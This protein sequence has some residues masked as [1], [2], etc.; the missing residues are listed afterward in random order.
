M[1]VLDNYR[2]NKSIAVLLSSGGASFPERLQ[3]ISRLR[4]LGGRAVPKLIRAL[5]AFESPAPVVELLATLLDNNT[6]PLFFE[7]LTSPNPLV[8]AGVVQVL[9]RRGTYDPNRLVELFQDAK[10]PKSRLVEILSAQKAD[11]NPR[12]LLRLLDTMDKDSR[13]PIFRLL[14]EVATESVTPDLIRRLKSDDWLLRLNIARILHRFST[15]AVRDALTALLADPHKGVRQAALEGLA[16][17]KMPVDVAPICKLLRDPDLTVQSKAIEAIGRI[18]DAKAVEYLLDILQD[19]SEY[20]RR[21]AVEVLNQVG[22][23]DAIKDLL[24]ALRDKDWWVRVRAAD[25]LGTIGGTKVVDAVLALVRDRDEFIR[26]TA[27]EILNVTKDERAVNALLMALEDPD[28]W[29]RERAADALAGLGDRRAVPA[30]SS[31]MERYPESAAVAIRALASFGDAKVVPALVAQLNSQQKTVREEALRALEK[32]T[33]A[34]QASG[35]RRGIKELLARASRDTAEI[36]NNVLSS[37]AA[38]VGG[39]GRPVEVPSAG[40][41]SA[42]LSYQSL[43]AGDAGTGLATEPVQGSD[44]AVD[45]PAVVYIS[46]AAQVID[47]AALEPGVVLADRYRVLRHVGSGA[48][49]L[50]VLVEDTVIREEIILKFLKPHVAADGNVIKR[51]IHELRYARKI[52]HENVIRIYDF[53]TFGKSYAISMEYFPSHALTADLKPGG[54]SG[55]RRS[56]KIIQDVC[57]GMTVAHQADVV[58][59]DLKPGNVLINDQD[60]VK[61]VDFGLAAA[62]SHTDSR[63]TTAGFLVG[64]PTY[65]APEQVRGGLF[66]ARSDIYSL[67]VIM[68]EMF[69]G[70]PPYVGPDP[71]AILYQ[72]VEGNPTPPRQLNPELSPGLEA[73]VLKAMALRPAERY[74]SMEDL[75]LS[76]E[77]LV[78]QEQVGWRV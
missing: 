66:D 55:D 35:V 42:V 57:R 70:R 4:R 44:T 49:G 8:V 1:G 78:Q 64:T 10:V 17:I 9:S 67:G 22:N 27:V 74:Q 48:F 75:R 6:L 26:R 73:V 63:L 56:V 46:G 29:V 60:L 3:A 16:S 20:V 25:A 34:T 51:F 47:A 50:V 69:T 19:E 28:W 40:P 62:S 30:L 7:A 24:G 77:D 58:H 61:I 38:R 11:L 41:I 32:L 54:T 52:T 12:A 71:M 23:T 45:V 14:D 15:E 21:A 39:Q 5:A 36:A 33:D 2:I 72:H 31:M 76:L 59:R 37:I 18:N 68:Y 53:I 43:L 13:T 65:M